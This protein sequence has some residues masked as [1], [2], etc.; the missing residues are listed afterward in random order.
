MTPNWV[1]SKLLLPRLSRDGIS[2]S[3]CGGTGKRK[4]SCGGCVK[5]TILALTAGLT[6]TVSPTVIRRLPSVGAK[7]AESGG[8]ERQIRR[9]FHSHVQL[10]RRLGVTCPELT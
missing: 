3:L 1:I 8:K 10:P 9:P 7:D 5:F 4:S 2:P 6:Q